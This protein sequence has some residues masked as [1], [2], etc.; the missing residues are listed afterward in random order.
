MPLQKYS[1]ALASKKLPSELLFK[2]KLRY[3]AEA[4]AKVPKLRSISPKLLQDTEASAF[5]EYPQKLPKQLRPEL[6]LDSWAEAL[7][8]ALAEARFG[9]SLDQCAVAADK[10]H[11]H[12]W[13]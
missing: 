5:T 3:F 11:V 4:S 10:K 1:A 9:R 8:E 2:P 6:R 13:V 7:A 12:I